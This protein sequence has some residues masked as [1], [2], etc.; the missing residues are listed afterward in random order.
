MVLNDAV[1]ALFTDPPDGEVPDVGNLLPV[2]LLEPGDITAA[3]AWLISDE[4]RYVTGV[5]LPVDAGF[6]VR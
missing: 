4:A 1:A 5:A 3:V 6:T 2:G